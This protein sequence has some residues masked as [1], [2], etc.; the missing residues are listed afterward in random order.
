MKRSTIKNLLALA[1]SK[2]DLQLY[3]VAKGDISVLDYLAK[4]AKDNELGGLHVI[5]GYNLDEVIKA[6]RQ[7]YKRLVSWCA[8][9]GNEQYKKLHEKELSALEEYSEYL[10]LDM[11][12]STDAMKEQAA[13]DVAADKAA[14]EIR[15]AKRATKAAK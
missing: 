5:G 8:S 12:T 14:A 6:N 7:R 10:L 1:E 2:S 15:A 13:K 9:D 3:R 11:L 4:F